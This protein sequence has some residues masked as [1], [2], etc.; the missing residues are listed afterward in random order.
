MKLYIG[1]KNYSSWSLRGWLACK[2]SG[3]PFEEIVVPLYDDAWAET[4]LREEFQPSAGKVPVLW[5]GE[6][7]VWDSLGIIDWLA[8]RTHRDRFWPKDPVACGLARSMAAE[9]HSGYMAL[10]REFSMNMR[11]RHTDVPVSPEAHQDVMRILSLWAEARAR[12]G[13]GGPFLFGSFG[14]ADIMFAPVVSR[15][16]T[17]GFT[18][19]GFARA[20]SEAVLGHEWMAQWTEAALA[21]TWVIDRFER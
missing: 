5:D 2:Q 18:L 7:V 16:E 6:A 15:F 14:A 20:Y 21:E 19:P 3:L 1:N 9:M 17:Y 8:D 13:R 10:R 4:R 12:F 11:A